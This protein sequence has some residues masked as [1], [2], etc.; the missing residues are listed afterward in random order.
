MTT[1]NAKAAAKP[2]L[3]AS[4]VANS[5][6]IN[7]G[8]GNVAKTKQLSKPRSGVIG[9]GG[10]FT[11]LISGH[12]SCDARERVATVGAVTHVRLRFRN[13]IQNNTSANEVANLTSL[14]SMTVKASVEYNGAYYRVFFRGSRLATIE[15]GGWILSDP[16]AVDIPANTTFFVRSRAVVASNQIPARQGYYASTE[17]Y[18]YD[19]ADIVD[20]TGT[21]NYT[22]GSGTAQ[23]CVDAVLG[24]ADSILVV[25][26][27]IVYGSGDS[28][29]IQ[30]PLPVAFGWPKRW[31]NG[32]I[33]CDV[34]GFPGGEVTQWIDNTLVPFSKG[35]IPG[36]AYDFAVLAFGANDCLTKTAGQIQASYTTAVQWMRSQ[37]IVKVYAAKILPRTTS[38]DS[39]ATEENQTPM[40]GFEPGGVRDVVNAWFVSSGLFNGVLDTCTP[41]ANGSV[42]KA[43]KTTDGAHPKSDSDGDP[44]A[45]G[46]IA[47]GLPSPLTLL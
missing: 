31:T 7:V 30:N 13:F 20:G 9:F 35:I 27:S 14:A 17:G 18:R 29:L 32:I 44:D 6:Y 4:Q 28:G 24:N 5:D 10:R 26:D 22:T 19:G 1:P 39:W 41:V 42:W 3:I 38:T 45:H 15:P 40:T 2:S 36:V 12:T 43:S 46:E 23:F 8:N 34:H 37:G 21:T 16:V 25:G 33:G 11:T 47:A